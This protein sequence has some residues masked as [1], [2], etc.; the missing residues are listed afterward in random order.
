MCHVT[1]PNN[2]QYWKSALS[3][4]MSSTSYLISKAPDYHSGSKWTYRLN[5]KV[6]DTGFQTINHLP[7]TWT[8]VCRMRPI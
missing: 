1:C 4:E 5:S 7:A 2:I 8:H 6:A 3:R